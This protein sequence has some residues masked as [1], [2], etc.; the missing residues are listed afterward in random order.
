MDDRIQSLLCALR[1][2]AEEPG[3]LG[4]AHMLI[5]EFVSLRPGTAQRDSLRSALRFELLTRSTEGEDSDFWAE[6][7][8][9][10][11]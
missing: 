1:I 5:D 7:L 2:L 3:N 4:A 9:Y 6:I 10:V 8:G 11:G